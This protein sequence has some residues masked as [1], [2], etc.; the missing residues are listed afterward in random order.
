MNV[1]SGRELMYTNTD[2]AGV[3]C[4]GQT[5]APYRDDI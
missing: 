5:Y 4:L 2:S 1:R 3:H